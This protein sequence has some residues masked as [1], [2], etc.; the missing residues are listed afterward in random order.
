MQK[1]YAA[2][3]EIATIAWGGTRGDRYGTANTYKLYIGVYISPGVSI[4]MSG[5]TMCGGW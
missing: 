2:G 4:H 5:N 1:C 3:L